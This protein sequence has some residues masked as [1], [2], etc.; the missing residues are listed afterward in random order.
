[1]QVVEKL[2]NLRMHAHLVPDLVPD[3]PDAAALRMHELPKFGQPV[4]QV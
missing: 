1:L 4:Q 3:W 2:P